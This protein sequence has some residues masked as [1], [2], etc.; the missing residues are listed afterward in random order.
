M[1]QAEL[2]YNI[3]VKGQLDGSW[4][5]WF[6]GLTIN[7]ADDGCTTLSGP[8]PDQAALHGILARIRDLGLPLISLKCIAVANEQ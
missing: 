5:E 6:D 3:K 2:V 7:A 4:S 1:D 8:L